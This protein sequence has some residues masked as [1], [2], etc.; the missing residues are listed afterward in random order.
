[1]AYRILY[2][3]DNPQNMDLVLRIL[4]H[5]GG[6]EAFG[7]VDGLSGVEIAEQQHPDLIIMDINLPDI[8]GIEATRR[9]KALPGLNTVPIVAF[10]ADTGESDRKKYLEEGCDGF[11]AKPASAKILL[12]MV[13]KYL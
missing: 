10:T 6:Y 4:N 3:E 7:A 12:D 5:V 1:M 8:S 11:M 9:I 13:Q 2:I